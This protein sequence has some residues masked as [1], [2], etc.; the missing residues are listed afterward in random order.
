MIKLLKKR[1]N[2]KLFFFKK[3][4]IRKV[5]LLFKENRIKYIKCKNYLTKPINYY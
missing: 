3:I 4:S 2:F 5:I 1:I